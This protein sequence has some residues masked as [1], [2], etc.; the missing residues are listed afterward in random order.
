M[1][2]NEKTF[3]LW[4]TLPAFGCSRPIDAVRAVDKRDA[5]IK[6]RKKRNFSNTET[7]IY[8]I[9]EASKA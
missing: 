4:Y 9:H 5:R 8:S 7:E 2:E 6:L 3:E 1:R